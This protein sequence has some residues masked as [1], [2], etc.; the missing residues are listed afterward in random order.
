MGQVTFEVPGPG[1]YLISADPS[2][3]ALE[4]PASPGDTLLG[5]QYYD[6]NGVARTGSMP[7]NGTVSESLAAGETF[8][9]QHG[10]HTGNGVITAIPLS[11][12]TVGT[13]TAS[14]ILTGETAW[15]NGRKV[16]G[17]LVPGAYTEDATATAPDILAGETAY[18]ASG[19]VTGTMPNNGAVEET[20]SAGSAYII[21]EGYHNGHGTIQAE[22]LETQTP[23]TATAPQILVSQTAWVDGEQV[24]GTMP[25]NGTV[26]QQLSA[27]GSYTIPQGYH[28]G[29]GKVTAASLASQTQGTATASD[30]T[31][32]KTA[33]VNGVLL[34]GTMPV[35][36]SYTPY[37]TTESEP[38]LVRVPEAQTTSL[39]S[40]SETLFCVP[41][42]VSA[43]DGTE[44]T[45]Q[46]GDTVLTSTSEAGTATFYLPEGGAWAVSAVVDGVQKSGSVT[47]QKSYSVELA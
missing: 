16:T 40:T 24:E 35:Q 25:N 20:I 13:A 34:T 18:V 12:Q 38:H 31:E 30:I 10:F 33:W 36:Y 23:G 42:E 17:T 47:V 44:V 37:V 41:L 32:G 3:P 46:N 1:M 26:N 14:A 7:N 6:S 2:M 27:G 43:P 11:E 4:A 5:K 8:Q 19:K 21:P 29:S 15:V 39:Q 22:S 28:S 9:I 45:A